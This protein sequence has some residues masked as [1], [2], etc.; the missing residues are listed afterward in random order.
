MKKVKRKKAKKP[1]VSMKKMRTIGGKASA[2]IIGIVVSTI[3]GATVTYNLPA[4]ISAYALPSG[5]DI[6]D[7][8]GYDEPYCVYFYDDKPKLELYFDNN[9]DGFIRISSINIVV[10]ECHAIDYSDL[11]LGEYG[12]RGGIQDIIYLYAK[13]NSETSINPC[14]LLEGY[15]ENLS[16]IKEATHSYIEIEGNSSDLFFVLLDVNK[17]GLYEVTFEIQ[18]VYHGREHIVTA[19]S[20]F[21]YLN[22]TRDDFMTTLKPK[23]N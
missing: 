16:Q 15:P 19:D 3:I 12:G 11:S 13:I 14:V 2:W 1:A 6:Y 20:E 10:Q 4:R 22:R 7:V 18:Y 9:N 23:Y 8:I 17:Q 21:V 5:I